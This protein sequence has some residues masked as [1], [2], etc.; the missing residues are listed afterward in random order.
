MKK[1]KTKYKKRKGNP[2]W[3]TFGSFAN[4]NNAEKDYV[5]LKQNT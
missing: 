5:H 2:K 3:I 4:K 1:T